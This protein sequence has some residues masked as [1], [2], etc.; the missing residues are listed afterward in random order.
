[1]YIFVARVGANV[2][3]SLI[4]NRRAPLVILG[5]AHLEFV[6]TPDS[7]S[8][9]GALKLLDARPEKRPPPPLA[10]SP[11]LFCEII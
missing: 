2:L 3:L 4:A 10:T 8:E 11:S 9:Y 5:I 6:T 1:M 7:V